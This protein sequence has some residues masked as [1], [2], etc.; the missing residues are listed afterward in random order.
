MESNEYLIKVK[1]YMLRMAPEQE[2]SISS[3]AKDV[4]LFSETVKQIMRE[5]WKLFGWQFEIFDDTLRRT[6]TK[7]SLNEYIADKY[8][9]P[10]SELLAS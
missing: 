6:T 3:I 2:V 7:N 1:Q 4:F 5:N 10:L 8:N 9:I